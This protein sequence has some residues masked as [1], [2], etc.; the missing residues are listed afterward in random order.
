MSAP[1]AAHTGSGRRTG[2]GGAASWVSGAGG[3]D[4]WGDTQLLASVN[5]QGPG[6]KLCFQGTELNFFFSF[7]ALGL[8]WWKY[9]T[10]LHQHSLQNG[11]VAIGPCPPLLAKAPV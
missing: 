11:F 8:G 10:A 5:V 1:P 2:T 4:V 7:S 6:W 9:S 3:L